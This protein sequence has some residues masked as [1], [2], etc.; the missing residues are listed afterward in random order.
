MSWVTCLLGPRRGGCELIAKLAACKDTSVRKTGFYPPRYIG[1]RPAPAL[2]A[3]RYSLRTSQFSPGPP[4]GGFYGGS[5]TCYDA[6]CLET[7]LTDG[8]TFVF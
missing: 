4:Y 3:R 7:A 6:D 1:V 5:V 2:Q 8:F